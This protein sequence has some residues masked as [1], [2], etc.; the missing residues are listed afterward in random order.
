MSSTAPGL[1]YFTLLYTMAGAGTIDPPAGPG[2][3]CKTC[4]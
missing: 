3:G 1:I 2:T 4:L